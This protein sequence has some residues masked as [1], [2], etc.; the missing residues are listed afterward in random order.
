MIII[1][2]VVRPHQVLHH[3]ASHL[4][5]HEVPRQLI[6]ARSLSKSSYSSSW[7]LKAELKHVW[8]NA[9]AN[10]QLPAL[11]LWSIVRSFNLEISCGPAQATY[12]LSMHA[13]HSEKLLAPSAWT[14]M[15]LVRNSMR[16]PTISKAAPRPGIIPVWAASIRH[17]AHHLW[18]FAAPVIGASN[19][20]SSGLNGTRCHIVLWSLR[21]ESQGEE[22]TVVTKPHAPAEDRQEELDR[23]LC[24]P[25]VLLLQS[26]STPFR[27]PPSIHH[28]LVGVPTLFGN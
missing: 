11:P 19:I 20:C 28:A 24:A 4:V 23:A 7:E 21:R 16:H 2:V 25:F 6:F 9:L 13:V 18:I 8:V 27:N 17:V 22:M 5:V 14:H 15:M 3:Q 26:H 1:S 10:S 12:V